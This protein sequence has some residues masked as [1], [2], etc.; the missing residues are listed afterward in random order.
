MGHSD[1]GT[2]LKI[3][4]HVVQERAAEAPPG[5][6]ERERPAGSQGRENGPFLVKR[7]R[8]TPKTLQ[9]KSFYSSTDAVR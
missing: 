5:R 3:Y 2:T 8:Q 9:V 7:Q 1:P 4:T 6:E